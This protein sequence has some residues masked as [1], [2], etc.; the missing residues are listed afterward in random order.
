[1]RT[2]QSQLHSELF[3]IQ[4]NFTQNDAPK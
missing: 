4:V 1:M 2:A 3:H